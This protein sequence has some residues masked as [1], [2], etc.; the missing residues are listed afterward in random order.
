MD[1]QWRNHSYLG[2][3]LPQACS[4]VEQSLERIVVWHAIVIE[5]PDPIVSLGES[6]VP[7]ASFQG[8]TRSNVAGH[9]ENCY[10]RKTLRQHPSGAVRRCI[11]HD[12]DFLQW[13]CL[14]QKSSHLPRQHALG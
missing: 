7:H 13:R 8:P 12:D 2:G 14:L 3:T 5:R 1:R 4:S 9:T 10:L 6:C 11:V